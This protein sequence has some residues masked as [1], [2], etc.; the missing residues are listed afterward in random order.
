[1]RITTAA[2]AATAAA[3][4]AT[5]A[6]AG[7]SSAPGQADV[8]QQCVDALKAAH[9]Q[10]IKGKPEAC[11]PLSEDDYATLVTAQVIDDLGWTDEDGNFDKQKMLEDTIPDQ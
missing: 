5:L 7:C 4:A 8:Q 11:A 6:L 10:G 1:M 9:A 2:L 3:L